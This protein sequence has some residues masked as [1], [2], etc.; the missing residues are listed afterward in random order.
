MDFKP[1]SELEGMH[2]FLAPSNPAWL[3]DDEDKLIAR[4]NKRQKAQRGT[5][6]HAWA[7]E[8]IRLGRL[9]PEG[10][11]IIAQYINDGIRWRMRNEVILFFSLFGFGSADSVRYD[12]VKRVLRVSD[13]KTGVT[14]ASF[15]QLECY[16]ALFCLEYD[17]NP[18]EIS[19]ELRIYQGRQVKEVLADPDRIFH[20]MDRYKW[21][22]K[23]LEEYRK[24]L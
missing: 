8:C 10:G 13:L 2:S 22:T 18:F 12:I 11:D 4:Y 17:L 7:H 24:E 1:H 5:E 23:V 3:N 9:Q 21:A 15:V 14:I 20:I 6:L 19:I 16:A